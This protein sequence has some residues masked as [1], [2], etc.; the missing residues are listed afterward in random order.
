[1]PRAEKAKED[2]A[3]HA[4]KAP[5]FIIVDPKN[6]APT[7]TGMIEIP[8]PYMIPAMVFPMSMDSRE[9]GEVRNLSKVWLARSLGITTGPIE[10]EEKKRVWEMRTGICEASGIFLPILKERK[11]LK[12]KSIPNMMDGGRV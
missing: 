11:R 8:A 2:R 6:A 5:R 9:T 1:M 10:D 7:K 3:K 12:G 4:S